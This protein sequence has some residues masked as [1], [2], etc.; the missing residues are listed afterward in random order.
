MLECAANIIQHP[1]LWTMTHKTVVGSHFDEKAQMV[2]SDSIPFLL[3]TQHN[4]EKMTHTKFECGTVRI[5]GLATVVDEHTKQEL[6]VCRMLPNAS[7]APAT[8]H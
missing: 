1:N 2:G 7:L 8:C 3:M 6:I 4:D 5:G